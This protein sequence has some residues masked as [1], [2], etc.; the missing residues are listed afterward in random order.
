MTTKS[1]TYSAPQYY[2]IFRMGKSVEFVLSFLGFGE[3]NKIVGINYIV[4]QYLWLVW[5]MKWN[6]NPISESWGHRKICVRTMS[7]GALSILA[8]CV[9]SLSSR[10]VVMGDTHMLLYKYKWIYGFRTSCCYKRYPLLQYGV[11]MVNGI[12]LS[13]RHFHATKWYQIWEAVFY[14]YKF[15][16]FCAS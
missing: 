15:V 2:F 16:G 1:I 11:Y 10:I 8:R 4:W 14:Q 3:K 12:L 7:I 13:W 5:Y 9:F 6:C